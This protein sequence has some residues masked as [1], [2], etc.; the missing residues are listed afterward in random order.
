MLVTGVPREAR[1]AGGLRSARRPC[2][3]VPLYM[4]V[5]KFCLQI[6]PCRGDP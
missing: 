6:K 1:G 5:F 4:D 3:L 2:A